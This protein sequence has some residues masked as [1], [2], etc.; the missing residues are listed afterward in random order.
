MKDALK[1]MNR[2][3]KDVKQTTDASRDS[4][5]LVHLSA[6]AKK[7][8]TDLNLGDHSTGIDVDEFFSKCITYMRNSGPLARDDAR[9]TQNRRRTTRGDEDDD[10][11]EEALDLEY[12]GRH[13]CFPHN[14]RPPT[15]SFLLG[16]LSVEKRQRMQTQRRARQEKD[17]T[18]REARPEALTRSDLNQGDEKGLVT[19]C[20][21]IHK[22]LKKHCAQVSQT[23]E[24]AGF[25]SVEQL[26][27]REGQ[28]MMKK[29]RIADTGG[30][31][32]FDFVLNPRSFGQTIE[33]LFYVSF[34]IKEGSFGIQNDSRD[35]PTI[36]TSPSC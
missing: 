16:P 14:S 35:L 26:H 22:Q 17:T 30:V 29:H 27:T 28:S 18:T 10:V 7:K 23:L 19:I 1:Q 21:G 4:K 5:L 8:A 13:A 9:P 34:L 20:N 3:F 33:N 12:L 32:L 31:S 11:A 25:T 15:G 2:N 36:S 6:V 24:S